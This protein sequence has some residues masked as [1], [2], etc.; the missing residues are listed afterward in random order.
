MKVDK[1]NIVAFRTA[2]ENDLTQQFIREHLRVLEDIGLAPMFKPNLDWVNDPE[3][4]MVVA[5]HDTMGMVGGLR[6]QHHTTDLPMA[7]ETAVTKLDKRFN[8]MIAPYKMAGTAELCGLWVAHR[9]VGNGLH[10]LL[11]PAGVAVASQLPITSLFTFA[12][13]YMLQVTLDVGFSKI[14]E[15]GREGELN[16][17]IPSIRSYPLLIDDLFVLSNSLLKNRHQ[18]LSLRLRPFQE[19]LVDPKN[20]AFLIRFALDRDQKDIKG[21]LAQESGTGKFRLSA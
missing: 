16:Y 6:I 1:L 5:I 10:K 14:R 17:P 13:E 15:V 9:Y 11:I 3:S 7:I 2:R 12:A 21:T 19:S 20:K 8:E 4:T 18:I